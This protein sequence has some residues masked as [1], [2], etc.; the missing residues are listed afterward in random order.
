MFS[1]RSSGLHENGA[2]H[3][4]NTLTLLIPLR[5]WPGWRACLAAL[6]WPV[7]L[8]FVPSAAASDEDH[9]SARQ[10][11][12]AG[13][14]LPLPVIL[15]RVAREFPGQV[16]EVELEREHGL[17]VYKLR[18]LQ[19]GGG[20]VKVKVNARTAEVLGARSRGRRE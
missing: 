5:P 6:A 1:G 18:L 17:W 8:A 4:M 7:C 12:Q 15:D 16:L 2:I 10:A 14:V 11:V 9:E 13:V 3:S 19:S 20:M